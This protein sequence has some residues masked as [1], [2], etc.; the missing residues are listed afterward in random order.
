MSNENTHVSVY[1]ILLVEAYVTLKHKPAQD[2]V[3]METKL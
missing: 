3:S 2:C 1:F